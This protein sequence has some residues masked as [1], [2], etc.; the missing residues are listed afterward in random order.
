MYILFSSMPCLYLD[1][2]VKIPDVSH[3]QKKFK[4]IDVKDDSR[5]E[6]F[7]VFMGLSDK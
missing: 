2:F 1:W 7:F 5:E 3:S 4:V 6:N